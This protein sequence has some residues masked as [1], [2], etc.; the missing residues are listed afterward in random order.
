M[1]LCCKICLRPNKRECKKATTRLSK[2]I[3][4]IWIRKTSLGLRVL[5][6]ANEIWI[7]FADRHT[8]QRL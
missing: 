8:S 1:T 3:E 2:T 7:C 6:L 4:Q 5:Q